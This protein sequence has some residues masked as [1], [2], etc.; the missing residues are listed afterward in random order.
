MFSQKLT[1]FDLNPRN[2]P[3]PLFIGRRRNSQYSFRSG[4]ESALTRPVDMQSALTRNVG[5]PVDRPN[6]VS[7]LLISST[8]RSTDFLGVNSLCIS[9]DRRPTE[10]LT[11]SLE[12]LFSLFFIL[13]LYILHLGE[14]FSNFSQTPM[15]SERNRHM[16][17]TKSTHD[18]DLCYPG[19][20]DG[21]SQ[22][23][24]HPIS[25]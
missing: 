17:S 21:R 22:L 14:D 2:K 10:V 8:N 13:S 7:P 19:E 9:I 1:Q 24:R 25:T 15:N 4:I 23:N 18:L 16:I 12:T 3:I 20:I 11:Q 5:R 6:W